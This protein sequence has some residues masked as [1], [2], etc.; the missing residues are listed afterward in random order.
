MK[1]QIHI[2][3]LKRKL[4]QIKWNVYMKGHNP[5]FGA[6]TTTKNWQETTIRNP[7]FEEI[8]IFFKI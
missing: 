1:Q 8:T 6:R 3:K 2:P 7:H 5:T 4:R